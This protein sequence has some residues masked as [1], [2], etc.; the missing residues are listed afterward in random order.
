MIG[1]GSHLTSSV[2]DMLVKQYYFKS[3]QICN[4]NLK[5]RYYDCTG[6]AELKSQRTSDSGDCRT[7]K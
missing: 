2:Y 3:S 7:P 5:F 4:S 6:I 1:M